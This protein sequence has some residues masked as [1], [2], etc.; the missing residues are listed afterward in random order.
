[1][2][3]Y[4]QHIMSCIDWNGC[5]VDLRKL[6]ERFSINFDNL[7][8]DDIRYI[9]SECRDLRDKFEEADKVPALRTW[10]LTSVGFSD[11]AYYSMDEAEIVKDLAKACVEKGFYGWKVE[12]VKL[13]KLVLD[14]Y[15]ADRK[16]WEKT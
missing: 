5:Y 15:I 14:G 9:E 7:S 12:E 16:E 10:R 8:L 1:M 2:N 11:Q 6:M 4:E 13:S 3:S